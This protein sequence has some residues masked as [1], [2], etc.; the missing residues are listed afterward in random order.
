[1]PDEVLWHHFFEPIPGPKEQTS[2]LSKSKIDFS[3]FDKV[4]KI[5]FNSNQSSDQNH[6]SIILNEATEKSSDVDRLLNKKNLETFK[7]KSISVKSGRLNSLNTGI[8]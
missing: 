8:S 4:K 7:N 6:C 3:L 1:V 5:K 2:C